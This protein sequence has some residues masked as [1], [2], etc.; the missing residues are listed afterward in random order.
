MS[1]APAREVRTGWQLHGFAAGAIGA[2]A[3]AL[4]FLVIDYRDGRP[5]WTP[6]AL[7]AALFR[8]DP[9]AIG[10]P[11]EPVLVLGYTALHGAVFVGFGMIAAFEA[12]GGVPRIA[13]EIAA[14]ALAAVV[15]FVAFGLTFEAFAWVFALGDAP[16]GTRRTFTANALAALAMAGYLAAVRAR[17]KR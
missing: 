16:L 12:L 6:N 17:V 8:G 3:I 4:V 11:V 14:A 2:L 1:Q 15:L 10:K 9:L 13:H 5:F 7:G